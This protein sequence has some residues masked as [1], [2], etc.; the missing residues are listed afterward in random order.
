MIQLTS[1]GNTTVKRSDTPWWRSVHEAEPE[2]APGPQR[3][4]LWRARCFQHRGRRAEP[5]RCRRSPCR[6][7]HGEPDASSATSGWLCPWSPRG[8]AEDTNIHSPLFRKVDHNLFKQVQ[9]KKSGLQQF[10]TASDL[11]NE[12]TRKCVLIQML[13]Y[14]R[15]YMILPSLVSNLQT[16]LLRWFCVVV[17]S[18]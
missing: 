8:S 15:L 1:N 9:Q 5:W 13:S 3:W 2:F 11:T 16:L 18:R 10:P 4:R 12:L 17:Y 6:A 7:L 14:G